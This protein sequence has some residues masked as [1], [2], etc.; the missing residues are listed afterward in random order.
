MQVAKGQFVEINWIALEPNGRSE[1]IP[2]STKK[3]PLIARVKGF[4]ADDYD[5]SQEI[6]VVTLAGRTVR[7]TLCDANPHYSHDFG[8][9]QPELLRVGKALRKELE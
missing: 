3:V 1:H 2:E 5:A 4:A 9:P 6:S 8:K 7:G